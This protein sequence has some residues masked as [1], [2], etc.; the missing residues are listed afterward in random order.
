MAGPDFGKQI[1][2]LP[3]G[4]WIVVVAGGLGIAYYTRR[5]GGGKSPTVVED[6]SG[7]PGVGAGASGFVNASPITVDNTPPGPATNEEW[8]VKAINYLIAQGYDPNEADNAIRKYLEST[9]LNQQEYALVRIALA[10]LGSPPVPL[11]IPPPPP[12]P[13]QPVTPVT[14]PPPAPVQPPPAPQIRLVMVTPWPTRRST[15]WGIALDFYGNG[16]RW[17]ELY[18]ANRKGTTRPDGSPGYISNPQYLRPGDMVYV[19]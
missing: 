3:L 8:A 17:P 9:Q 10:K 15:L 14:P 1:G 16:N 19:P 11:P 7:D 12:D 2:P 6:T 4:A 13:V 18:N 5:S